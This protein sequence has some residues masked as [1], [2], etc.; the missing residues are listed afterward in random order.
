MGRVQLEPGIILEYNDEWSFKIMPNRPVDI[1]DGTIVYASDF[2]SETPD[3]T[4]F[5]E[6][7]VGVEF[8]HCNLSNVIVPNQEGG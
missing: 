5:R 2:S 3:S 6:N 8:H 4:P 7:M 1:P